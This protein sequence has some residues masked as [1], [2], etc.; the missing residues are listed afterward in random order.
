M[1]LFTSIKREGT[2]ITYIALKDIPSSIWLL[3]AFFLFPYWVL[4]ILPCFPYSLITSFSSFLLIPPLLPYFVRCGFISV[5]NHVWRF[6]CHY[7]VITIDKTPLLEVVSYH[8]NQ[9]TSS[10]HKV[11][12]H[13]DHWELVLTLHLDSMCGQRV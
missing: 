10:S 5:K 9:W 8:I 12:L 6:F 4:S 2:V 7:Q 11:G 1:L 3:A 13:S